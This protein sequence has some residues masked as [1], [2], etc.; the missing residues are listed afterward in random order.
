[1]T[2]KDPL[3]AKHIAP[4]RFDQKINGILQGQNTAKIKRLGQFI[5]AGTQ[6]TSINST[7]SGH[8]QNT[9]ALLDMLLYASAS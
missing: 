7:Y 1:M 6:G 8:E 2:V 5:F 4:L 3:L 9:S